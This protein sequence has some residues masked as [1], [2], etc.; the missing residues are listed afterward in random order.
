[1]KTKRKSR[2]VDCSLTPPFLTFQVPEI[3]QLFLGVGKGYRKDLHQ[4]EEEMPQRNQADYSRA[5]TKWKGNLIEIVLNHRL[6]IW[7]EMPFLF[8][9]ICRKKRCFF[10]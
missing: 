2:K 3:V 4:K 8:R 5:L 9:L 1:M 10:F 6:N 7:G